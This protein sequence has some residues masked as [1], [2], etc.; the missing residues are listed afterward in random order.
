MHILVCGAHGFIG[1]ALCQQLTSEGHRVSKGV[2]HAVGADEIAID[3][4][5]DLAPESWLP[6]LQGIDVVINA[7][8]IIV[9]RSRQRFDSIH[10]QAPIALFK[11]CA[12]SNVKRVIQIS[13]LGADRGATPYF[14]SKR[15][16]DEYL[17]QQRLEWQ[18]VRPALVYGSDGSSATLFRILA[19][20]PVMFLPAGGTQQVQPVHLDD[21]VAVVSKLV[22]PTARACQCIEIAGGQVL[23]YREMLFSLRRAMGF[24][25]ALTINLPATMVS[26][27]AKLM[28][29]IPGAMLTSD[30]WDMLQVGNTADVGAMQHLLGREPRRYDAFISA[31][32]APLLHAQALAAWRVPLLRISLAVVWLASGIVSAFVYPQADS[33]QLLAKIGLQG[34]LAW[35]ALYGAAGLD[36]VFGIASL[37]KPGRRLWLLQFVLV[38]AYSLIVAIALP[39]FLA[40][41]F[42]PI[43]KNLPILAILLLLMAEDE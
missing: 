7:I 42:A 39:Q 2:R 32:D 5:R 36:L 18:I 9:E 6:R 15:A 19:S 22:A 3:Y 35:L 8:G 24:R 25:P 28:D 43:I 26:I 10:T 34:T 4:T 27:A 16:A 13:A 30:N 41:P 33:L 17:M 21:L 29:S 23:T 11:A 40:H 37:L 31:T 1:R 12:I 14:V 38:V 20:L